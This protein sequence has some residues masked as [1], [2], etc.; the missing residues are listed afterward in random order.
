MVSPDGRE[1]LVGSPTERENL[2]A[3]G[4]RA[5]TEPAPTRTAD[6]KPATP[7]PAPKK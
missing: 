4:Y 6:P 3:Q 7:R 5:V 1:C 2:H